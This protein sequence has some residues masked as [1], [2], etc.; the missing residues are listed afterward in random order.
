MRNYKKTTNAIN[1]SIH[2]LLGILSLIW[3]S[4]IAW[5]V[6][7]SFNSAKGVPKTL[8]PNGYTLSNYT[9]LFTKT[10]LFNYPRWFFH[11]QLP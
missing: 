4:P 9:N 2:I 5:L 8:I 11:P 7:A 3:L 6:L 1:F 10:D